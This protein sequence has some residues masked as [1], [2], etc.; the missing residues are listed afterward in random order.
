MPSA[1]HIFANVRETNPNHHFSSLIVHST[2]VLS[3]N[4]QRLCT[5]LLNSTCFVR[6]TS[7]RPGR[8][9][10]V[11]MQKSGWDCNQLVIVLLLHQSPVAYNEKKRCKTNLECDVVTHTVHVRCKSYVYLC[12]TCVRSHAVSAFIFLKS[13][14]YSLLHMALLRHVIPFFF[15][16]YGSFCSSVRDNQV[17]FRD[18]LFA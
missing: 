4:P 2:F 13:V 14:D 9:R 3:A 16:L 7:V 17:S 12:K 15:F 8:M 11:Y 5:C 18:N 10:L 6:L 1:G